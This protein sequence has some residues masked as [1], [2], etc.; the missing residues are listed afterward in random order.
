MCQSCSLAVCPS[1]CPARWDGDD[2]IVCEKCE[3]PITDGD[4]FLGNGQYICGACA[5]EL[6]A[7]DLV[8][9]CDFADTAELLEA[10]GFRRTE[11]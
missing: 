3:E 7:S 1:R 6:T 11:K 8:E 4:C 10:L 2:L 5:D 9:L